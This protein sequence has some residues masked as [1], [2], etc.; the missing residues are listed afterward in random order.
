MRCLIEAGLLL[1]LGRDLLAQ[2]GAGE[3][4]REVVL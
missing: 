1:F 4:P 2:A 3:D